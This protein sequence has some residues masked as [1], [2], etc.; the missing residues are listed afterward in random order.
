LRFVRIQPK[1]QLRQT[2]ISALKFDP[3]R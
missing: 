1:P 2:Q 3:Q